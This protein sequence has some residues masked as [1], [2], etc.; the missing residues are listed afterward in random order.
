MSVEKKY[1]LFEWNIRDSQKSKVPKSQK[2]SQKHRKGYQRNWCSNPPSLRQW[3][4]RFRS[5]R[6]CDKCVIETQELLI[7]GVYDSFVWSPY[8]LCYGPVETRKTAIVYYLCAEGKNCVIIK[9]VQFPFM[10]FTQGGLRARFSSPA[11]SVL[12]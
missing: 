4:L 10:V 8:L 6:Y 1:T 12:S 5:Y 3:S 7:I 9:I 2:R 11:I